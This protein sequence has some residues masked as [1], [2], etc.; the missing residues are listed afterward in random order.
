MLTS[1]SRACELNV[2][3]EGSDV[4]HNTKSTNHNLD[5]INCQPTRKCRHKLSTKS[6]SHVDT[7]QVG[8][9]REQWDNGGETTVYALWFKYSCGVIVMRARI[10]PK[11]E[12][13]HFHFF[14]SK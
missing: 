6:V 12:C 11:N 13:A 14:I 4:D 5:S 2:L 9:Q 7:G 3:S 1:H 8:G 10:R